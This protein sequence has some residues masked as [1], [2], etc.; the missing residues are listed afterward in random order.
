[1][2]IGTLAIAELVI[3]IVIG[4]MIGRAWEKITSFFKR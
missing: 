2:I 4:F 3:G 1:M